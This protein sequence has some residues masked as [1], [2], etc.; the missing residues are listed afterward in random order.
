M[1]DFSN[2]IRTNPV[3]LRE[4]QLNYE[5][6]CL[7]ILRCFIQWSSFCQILWDGREGAGIVSMFAAWISQILAK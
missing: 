3:S 4:S 6:P 5:Y 2:A 7:V 1:I